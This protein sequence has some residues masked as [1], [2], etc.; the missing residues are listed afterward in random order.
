MKQK[1]KT[2]RERQTDNSCR[3]VV[4]VP[5]R[6][7]TL[8][9]TEPCLDQATRT[10]VNKSV[11]HIVDPKEKLSKLRVS[12]FSLSNMIASGAVA[13]LKPVSMVVDDLSVIDD[14]TSKAES[15][16]NTSNSN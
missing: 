3:V 10:V 8:A 1:F 9:M 4:S 13:Q 15:I 12:D 7:I 14:L 16:I 2:W 6:S 11:I 5:C